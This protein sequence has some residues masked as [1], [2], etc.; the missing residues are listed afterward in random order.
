MTARLVVL[1]SPRL[2]GV[3][4]EG[5]LPASL[6]GWLLAALSLRGQWV[7]REE[8][9]TL[10]WPDDEA[11]AAQ[12]K[13][14]VHLHRLRQR[15]AAWGIAGAL[16]AERQ[17]IRLRLP[18]D[19]DGFRL[20]L[21]RG[22]RAAALALYRRPLLD[23]WRLPGFPALEE[24]ADRERRQIADTARA[25]AI[26]HA[27]DL[28]HQQRHG[29]AIDGLQNLM[30]DEPLAEDLLQSLMRC[31]LEG[32]QASLGLQQAAAFVRRLAAELDL[33]PMPETLR[34]IEALRQA[35]AGE[36]VPGTVA[37]AATTLPVPAVPATL[38]D[39]PALVGRADWVSWLQAPRSAAVQLTGP[40]GIG[41]TTLL[42]TAWPGAVWLA[43]REGLDELPLHPFLQVLREQQ[44]VL[45]PALPA[46][47]LELARLVQGYADGAV[48]AADPELGKAR[49]FEALALAMLQLAA[50]LV[51]D[52]LH[53]ADA[54]TRE[55]L[56]YALHRGG[57]R[58][59][60]LRRSGEGGGAWAAVE[61][62]LESQGLLDT[63]E[64]PPLDAE[65]VGE[66]LCALAGTTVRPVRF[67]DW[68]TKGTGGNPF[69][70]LEVLRGLFDAGRLRVEGGSW[71][72]DVDRV[73]RDYS[74][75]EIPP[76]AMAATR[77]RVGRLPPDAQRLLAVAAVAGEPVLPVAGLAA[78]CGCTVD[79]V[80]DQGSLLESAGFLREERFAH[81]LVRQS[82][83]RGLPPQR[84]KHLHR[85]VA[86]WWEASDCA[87]E[88]DAAVLAHHWRAAG[89]PQRALPA[90][91]RAATALRE[92]G[93]LEESAERYADIAEQAV[94]P[95]LRLLARSALA[96]H[97]LLSDLAEGR[98]LLEAVLHELAALPPG[99]PL[100]RLLVRVHAALADNAVYAG[101]LARAARHV[102]AL[103]PALAAA[104]PEDRVHA[105]TVVVEVAMRRCDF[106]LAH[107]ALA[108]ARVA[109]PANVTLDIYAAMLAWCEVRLDAAIAGFEAVLRDHPAHARYIMVE[110]DL[111]VALHA[112]GAL[113]QAEASVRRGLVTWAGVP[114]AECLSQLNLGAILTSGG[115]WAE[116][117]AA[118]DLA[119]AAAR[120]Q[121]A[122]LFE[123]EALH[124][125]ARLQL[126]LGEAAEARR[127][128]GEA[129]A[130]L[131]PDGDALR[132]AQWHAQAVPAALAC[133]DLAAAGEHLRTAEALAVGQPHP[134]TAARLARAAAQW[135]L[136]AGDA[137]AAETAAD[138]LL[139]LA[140]AHGLGEHRVEG[141]LL[142]ARCDESAGRLDQAAA[143]RR[144]ALALAQERGLV[145]LAMP[146]AAATVSA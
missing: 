98:R 138:R 3:L 32:G 129:L 79:A 116:A 6:P 4:G 34:L 49:L 131:P 28:A 76:R 142:R 130:C 67:A 75:L 25:A 1:D 119:L 64:L 115:R 90:A 38:R 102:E 111:G 146:L 45:A 110:N 47:R 92:R 66:L 31:A 2:E 128:L 43:C 15:L 106:T 54:L 53:W 60:L 11:A 88:V 9:C 5:S 72:T 16:H 114:H 51:I 55:W 26:R 84:R 123:G 65:Q 40:P 120:Q 133:G 141:L 20:A 33:T 68:L 95:A 89:E 139:E 37:V 24:W 87:G 14:R 137:A 61:R 82:V 41:K 117:R 50:P 71:A 134:I 22:D 10:L 27:R 52:D 30:G 18:S 121:H 23:G 36:P 144:T 86:Q 78:V 101:D 12:H 39:A 29:E 46:Q 57:L 124:R 127:L 56:A 122:R 83:Y 100:T 80:I 136:G 7:A 63:R 74:E 91:L 108:Q 118:L 104:E 59:A 145:P 113:L 97:L 17:R 112:Q 58:I 96:E 19:V 107:Q 93:G 62:S 109:A 105:L 44:A 77:D 132:L 99:P 70:A 35:H 140:L 73:T 8:L 48:P 125:L 69:F 81:D 143:R 13:L 94:D 126:G 103:R 21:G 135:A 85:Q 42:R